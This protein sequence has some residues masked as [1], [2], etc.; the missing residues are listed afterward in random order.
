MA[1]T[2]SELDALELTGKNPPSAD[3]AMAAK[4]EDYPSATK[5]VFMV[6]ALILAM[7]L[8]SLDMTILGTAIPKITD[9]FH[10]LDQVRYAPWPI[11]TM[12]NNYT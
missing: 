8:A 4:L 2:E 7:F 6:I 3:V 9:D 11:L 5:L 10:S 12:P 1:P